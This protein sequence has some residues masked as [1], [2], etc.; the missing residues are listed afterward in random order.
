M[1][2]SKWYGGGNFKHLFLIR[3]DT[4]KVLV[5]SLIHR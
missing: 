3:E 2:I 1:H 5:N 4:E